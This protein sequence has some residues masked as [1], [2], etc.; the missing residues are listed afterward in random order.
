MGQQIEQHSKE[1][2]M[3]GEFQFAAERLQIPTERL[4]P[5]RIDD[6]QLDE[7]FHSLPNVSGS[8][9]DRPIYKAFG[10]YV[11]RYYP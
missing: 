7:A 8:D 1:A 6:A 9:F 4:T 5:I 2:F 10:I 3:D 11:K